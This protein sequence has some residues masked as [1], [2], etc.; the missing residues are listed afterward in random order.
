M[1]FFEECPSSKPELHCRLRSRRPLGFLTPAMGGLGFSLPAS[2]GVRMADPG[3]PV[4]AIL[5]DGSSLYAIQGLWSAARYGVGTLFVILANGRYA[6]M[7]RLAEQAGSTGVWPDFEAIDICAIARGF[8]CEA[9]RCEAPEE[10]ERTLDAVIPSLA[11]RRTPLVLE[12][13]VVPDEIY[14]S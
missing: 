12:A 3:R 9:V 13:R 1:V 14:V 10:V 5:G 11:D 7:D 8:G 6:I 4:V 2:I